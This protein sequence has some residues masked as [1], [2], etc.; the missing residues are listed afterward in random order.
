MSSTNNQNPLAE[1]IEREHA[2]A[3]ADIK[4]LGWKPALA[5]SQKR[6]GAMATLIASTLS[7]GIACKAECWYCCYFKVEVRAEEVFQ[8]VDHVRAHFSPERV[9][10]VQHDVAENVNALRGLSHEQQLA[11]HRKCAFL[12][13][14][15]CSIYEVRPARCRTC[16]ATDVAGCK[17]S[18]EEPTNLNIPN[19]LVP[20]LLYTGEAHLKGARQAFA[21]AGYD[22]DVYEMNA[23]LEMALA[24]STPKRRF[25]KGKRAFAGL[26]GK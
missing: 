23:A 5:A 6:Q 19:T 22:N 10:R 8:M 14:G 4:A 9:K 13:E 16:H 25:E 15:K 3:R 11:A 17:Q 26:L 21:D 18:W 12:D 7:P 2:L 24:D 1:I 20:A